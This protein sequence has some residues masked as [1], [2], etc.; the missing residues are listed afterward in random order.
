MASITL[1]TNG[2]LAK[3]GIETFMHFYAL[4]WLTKDKNCSTDG[5]YL[6][7]DFFP[8]SSSAQKPRTKKRMQKKMQMWRSELFQVK[9]K[10]LK[11]YFSTRC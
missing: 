10:G 1:D 5:R 6:H 8:I 3:D 4:L 9:C 7:P 2:T 11:H